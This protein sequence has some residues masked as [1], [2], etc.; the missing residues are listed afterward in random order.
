MTTRREFL[1]LAKTYN[2][3]KPPRKGYNLAGWFVSEKLDGGRCFWDGG[4]TRG[5]FTTDVPWANIYDPKTGEVKK[6]I[7]PVST[8]LWSRY[9]NP[10]MAPDWFLNGLPCLPLD[11][12]LF[13]GRGQFQT[14]MSIIRKDNPID[15]EWRN[16]QFAVYSS[17]PFE[18]VFGDGEIKNNNFHR[19]LQWAEIVEWLKARV[20]NLP[21]AGDF[22]TALSGSTFDQELLLLSEALET[23][24]DFAYLHPQTRLPDNNNEAADEIEHQLDKVLDLG[25]EGLILRSPE[26]IW[27]PKRMDH[28]LKYKPFSDDEAVITGFTSGRVGK[29]GLLHGKIGALITVYNGKRLEIS[30]LTH[31]EREFSTPAQVVHATENPGQDMPTDFSGK[32]FK[33]G[34]TV[35]FKYRELSDDGIPKEA[36]YFR[37]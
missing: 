7:K 8:G 10:I 11:G 13:A 31:D 34:D 9:G 19:T 20:V 32:H 6:K 16:V 36:R 5:M 33:A 1:Q 22:T 21:F 26:A 24:T 30:G 27:Y 2:P 28:I 12:E 4:V 3:K 14:T 29:E 25:G 18:A 17:P 35:T 15:E 37:K 23:P